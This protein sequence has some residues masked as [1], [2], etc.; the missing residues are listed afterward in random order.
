M[1]LRTA[2]S[3]FIYAKLRSGVVDRSFLAIV[4]ILFVVALVGLFT[5]GPGDGIT[6]RVV[7]DPCSSC[8]GT[9]VCAA[10]GDVVMNYP[11]ACTAQC[12]HARIVYPDLCERIPQA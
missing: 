1:F 3:I 2:A 4:S 12:E 7:Q 11:N 5:L 10:Q 8:T 6:G 9:P